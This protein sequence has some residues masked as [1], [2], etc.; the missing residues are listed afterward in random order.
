MDIEL[1]A[2]CSCLVTGGAGFIG[3]HLVTSLVNRGC[4]VRVL[5]NLST[6][7][8]DNLGHLQ[9]N[10][11][12][13]EGDAA[14]ACTVKEAVRGVDYVFHHA[15]M[16]SVPRSLREPALCHAWCASSTVEL[17]A[18]SA[19]ANVKRF[20]LASTSAAY[21]NS[22]FGSK[23]ETDPPAPLSPYAAPLSLHSAPL[24]LHSAPLRLQSTQHPLDPTLF[25][26]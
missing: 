5:D 3:S 17:L 16:A 1:Q 21:G 18:A 7:Y 19:Q 26:P 15:A 25:K 24:N 23:R 4:T 11:E 6:G 8:L 22:T 9:G 2:G 12:F 20:V 14:D 10:V 13:I